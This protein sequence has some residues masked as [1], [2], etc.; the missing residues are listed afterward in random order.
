MST[1]ELKGR[2]TGTFNIRAGLASQGGTLD[3]TVAGDGSLKLE[4]KDGLSAELTTA[5]G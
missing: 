4:P 5:G 1:E 3:I 2:W